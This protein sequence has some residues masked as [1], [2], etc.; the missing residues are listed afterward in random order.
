MKY[1]REHGCTWD[2]R[3]CT[4]A[5]SEGHLEVLKYAHEHAC[6]WST[7]RL[8]FGGNAILNDEIRAYVATF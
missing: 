7:P 4:S 8:P 5:A 2:T 1:A 3:T 6:T